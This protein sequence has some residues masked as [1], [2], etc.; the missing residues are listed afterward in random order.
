MRLSY[1][2]SN[3]MKEKKILNFMESRVHQ[4]KDTNKIVPNLLKLIHLNI[5]KN[6]ILTSHCLHSRKENVHPQ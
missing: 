4:S 2:I 6:K 5:N 3:S 1:I